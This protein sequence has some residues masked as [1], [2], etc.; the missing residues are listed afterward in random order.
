MSFDTRESHM[1]WGRSLMSL[2]SNLWPPLNPV[3]VIVKNILYPKKETWFQYHICKMFLVI[4]FYRKWS[5]LLPFLF[6]LSLH[7]ILYQT[8]KFI[9]PSLSL[10]LSLSPTQPN[11]MVARQCIQVTFKEL[12]ITTYTDAFKE[13]RITVN[14]D[15]VFI[16]R[17][18][19]SKT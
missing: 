2:L 7:F 6:F 16:F 9:N 1:L 8:I 19:S 18:Q 15:Y 3:F 13:L 11:T 4:H 5:Y 10:S 12:R 14:Q 17:S